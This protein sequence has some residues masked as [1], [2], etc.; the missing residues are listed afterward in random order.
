MI[1][2]YRPV[3]ILSTFAKKFRRLVLTPQISPYLSEEQHGFR[4]GRRVDT[5][6]LTFIN[7]TVPVSV[8]EAAAQVDETYFDFCKR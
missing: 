3:A 2:G 8:A 6:L 1:G 5:N 7:Y 4:S